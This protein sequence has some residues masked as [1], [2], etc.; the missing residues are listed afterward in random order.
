MRWSLRRCLAAALSLGTVALGATT[1]GATAADDLIACRTK[2]AIQI[3]KDGWTRIKAPEMDPST[4]EGPSVFKAFSTAPTSANRIYMTNGVVIKL[5]ADGGCTW[6][7]LTSGSNNRVPGVSQQEPDVYNGLA[8]PDDDTLWIT[9]YDDEGGV[10]HPHVY[11]AQHLGPQSDQA[12]VYPAVDVGLPPV[13]TPVDIVPAGRELGMAYLVVDTT[14]DPTTGDAQTPSRHL[15]TTVV[16]D[17]P[18]PLA[19]LGRS[20]QEIKLPSSFGRLG[21]IAASTYPETVWAYSGSQ[22]AY[23]TD[24][25]SDTPVWHVLP[26]MPGPIIALDVN[27]LGIATVVAKTGN[28]SI[29]RTVAADGKV[30]VSSS[31]LPMVPTHIAHGLRPDV[32]AISGPTGT[33]GYDIRIKKWVDITPKGIGDLRGLETANGVAE[34]YVVGQTDTELYRFDTFDGE[35]FIKPPDHAFTGDY[36][37]FPIGTIKEPFIDPVNKTITVKPGEVKDVDVTF[38]MPPAATPLDVYFLMDTTGSMGNAINGLRK[39]VGSIAD[40]MRKELGQSVC[41]GVGDFKDFNPTA[42]TE[43]FRTHQKVVCETDP[44]LPKVKAGLGKLQAN[45]GGTTRAEAQTIA[46]T[47]AVTGTGQLNPFVA[48]DQDAEFRPEAFK[49]IVLITDAEF[50]QGAG[51]PTKEAAIETL[52]VAGV[53]VVGVQVMTDNTQPEIARADLD[54]LARGTDTLAPAGGVDC[55]GDGKR[56]QYDL[57]EGEPLVCQTSG[58][59][60]NIGPVISTLLLGVKDPGTVAVKVTDP[61][62]V[63][64]DPIKGPT[65][66]IMNLKR[67]S[68]LQFSVPVSCTTAQDGLD[69]PV[70][71]SPTVRA[72]P[73]R[74]ARGEFVHGRFTVQCRATPPVKVP[75]PAPRI[76]PD[77]P[78]VDRPPLP[79][80]PPALALVPPP[81][82]PVQPISNINP[83]AGFSQQEEEQFQVATVTQDVQDQEQAEELELAMSSLDRNQRDATSGA[84]LAVG[85]L[86]LSTGAGVAYRR[87]LQRSHRFSTVRA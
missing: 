59:E 24:A 63:T 73:A 6:N 81:N 9:S 41:F 22:Y 30:L 18:A 48:A 49:I 79:R 4:K 80:P 53:R 27:R 23:A 66:Q 56:G 36:P 82:P 62:N 84:L 7:F 50:N 34:R 2:G 3:R 1:F 77:P 11:M 35:T 8:A 55:D 52:H 86:A 65:S 28:V 47:Q 40:R 85:A 68:I 25:R 58:S 78:V 45:G 20:W 19:T 71:L 39:D 61:F 15:Y 42:P 43:V 51:Y 46:L 17:N 12:P 70:D 83:N 14:P 74:N 54:Q 64:R 57:T 37:K 10:P 5:S 67:Q 16:H 31:R 26:P 13:G 32:Y 38:G 75:P 60:P 76:P 69:L 44:N 29:R 33:W 21:G 87:R 72:L